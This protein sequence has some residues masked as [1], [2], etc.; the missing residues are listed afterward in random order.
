MLVNARS[1][2]LACTR[3]KKY[4]FDAFSARDSYPLAQRVTEKAY[5]LVK[6]VYLHGSYF[7]QL[8][9]SFPYG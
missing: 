4:V 2:G 3:N 8:P 7:V 9:L 5:A 6:R 1:I